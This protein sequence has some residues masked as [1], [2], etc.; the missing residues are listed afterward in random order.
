LIWHTL[1][2]SLEA[3]KAIA[4]TQEVT[5]NDILLTAITD[6]LTRHAIEQKQTPLEDLTAVLWASVT[7]MRE[8]YQSVKEVPVHLHNKGLGLLHVTL[9]TDSDLAMSQDSKTRYS[10][11]LARISAQTRRLVASPEIVVTGWLLRL[12]GSLPPFLTKN[13]FG[14]VNDNPSISISNVMGPQFPVDFCNSPVEHLS[15]YVPPQNTI[16]SFVCILTLH[17][18]ITIG[19]CSVPSTATKGQQRNI[20]GPFMENALAKLQ[21]Q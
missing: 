13:V 8:A 4:R 21:Q 12:M 6:A 1:D 18:Q 5:V 2:T 10:S 3:V 20:C 17:D 15:F 7:P 9:P 14:Y 11:L 19:M 16:G